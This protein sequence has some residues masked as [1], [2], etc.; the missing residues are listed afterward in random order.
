MLEILIQSSWR[1]RHI[2]FQSFGDLKKQESSQSNRPR[3]IPTSRSASKLILKFQV[4][5]PSIF[6]YWKFERV[7]E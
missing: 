6:N 5:I 1:Q 2:I 7:F 4:S 3:K